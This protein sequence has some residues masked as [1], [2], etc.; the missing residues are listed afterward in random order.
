MLNYYFRRLKIFL[1]TPV[2][3]KTAHSE[4]VKTDEINY[5]R[6]LLHVSCQTH[7]AIIDDL[8]TVRTSFKCEL[9][10]PTSKI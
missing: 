1:C 10:L 6:F 9:P 2:T 5:F 8:K 4:A 3:V 7:Y